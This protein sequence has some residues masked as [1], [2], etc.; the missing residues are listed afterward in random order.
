MRTNAKFTTVSKLYGR[1]QQLQ[2]FSFCY[3]TCTTVHCVVNSEKK[4]LTNV[5]G[6]GPWNWRSHYRYDGDLE[7]INSKKEKS[8]IVGCPWGNDSETGLAVRMERMLQIGIMSSLY[9]L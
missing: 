9:R 5:L 1:C 8:H 2:G 3:G 6:W 7:Y 4:S